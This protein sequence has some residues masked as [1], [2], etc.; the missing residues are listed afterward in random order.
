MSAYTGWH[1][2]ARAMKDADPSLTMIALG[3]HFGVSASTAWKALNPDTTRRRNATDRARR[4]AQRRATDRERS[5]RMRTV[6][7]TC[8]RPRG[9]G[10]AS[11]GNA[12]RQCRS[13]V[14][15]AAEARR[16][17]LTAMYDAGLPLRDMAAQ[18][19]TSKGAV[20]VEL[21]RLRKA[22]RIGY[23]AGRAAA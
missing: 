19:G 22:G 12:P 3:E 2:E 21:N 9:I 23:R 7:D 11:S 6:C 18:L 8:G 13:C 14:E 1:V 10:S 4:R 5:K 20:A 17:R 15:A 16:E